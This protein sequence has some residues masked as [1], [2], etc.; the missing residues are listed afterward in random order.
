MQ[1]FHDLTRK[2]FYLVPDRAVSV[3]C[4]R[5]ESLLYAGALPNQ[6]LKLYWL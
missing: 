2:L 5:L 1:L 3:N 6:S 4:R